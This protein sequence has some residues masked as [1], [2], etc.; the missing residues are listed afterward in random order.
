[1]VERMLK[2]VLVPDVVGLL[3]H[4]GRDIADEA[5]VTLANPD[6]DGPPIGA[7]A[8]PGLF[9]ITWQDPR[10]S[11][12]LNQGDSVRVEVVE[13]GGA[14][15]GALTRDPSGPPALAAHAQTEADT[16]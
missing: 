16:V 15:N 13:H 4:V 3:F 11:F 6:P 9:Y 8:W 14:Q 2:R 10:A 5:G 1:M 12:E 7:I